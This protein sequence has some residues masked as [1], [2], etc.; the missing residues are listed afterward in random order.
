MSS[1]KKKINLY[2]EILSN[3]D[4]ESELEKAKDL[5][6]RFVDLVGPVAS[7]HASLER[8]MNRHIF[9][10]NPNLAS[11]TGLHFRFELATKIIYGMPKPFGFVDAGAKAALVGLNRLRNHLVHPSELTFMEIHALY[12]PII[13]FIEGNKPFGEHRAE[14][15]G[16]DYPELMAKVIQY[17]NSFLIGAFS[18]QQALIRGLR[19]L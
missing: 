6:P 13:K 16:L 14:M 3:F 5:F 15:A 10:C 12:S 17:F 18:S 4:A 19:N 8:A 2:A 11:V 7:C 9:L 1:E